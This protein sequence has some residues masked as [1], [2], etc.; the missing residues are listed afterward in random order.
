MYWRTDEGAYI[1]GGAAGMTR[2]DWV[3]NLRANPACAAWVKRRRF[4]A[5][6][7]ELHGA[8]Y[9]RA[10]SYAFARWPAASRYEMKSGR[11]VP[12]FRL[13]LNL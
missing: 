4:E 12:F 6:A 10:K 5:T 8:E 3:A 1:G 2:V 11:A 9:E 13:E 7:H